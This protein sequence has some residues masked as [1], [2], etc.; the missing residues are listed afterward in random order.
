MAAVDAFSGHKCLPSAYQYRKDHGCGLNETAECLPVVSYDEAFNA[1]HYQAVEYLLPHPERFDAETSWVGGLFVTIK[2]E[3]MFRG[4]VV[5]HTVLRAIN[6]LHRPYPRGRKY[7][8]ASVIHEVIAELPKTCQG[9]RLALEWM[10]DGFK[11]QRI[12]ATL[13]LPPPLPH[14]PI[15]P[16]AHLGYA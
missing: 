6:S 11:H 4:Q 13:C 16:C 12:S 14:M 1:F 10:R 7:K 2:G 8:P 3:I 9:S 5:L 15:K